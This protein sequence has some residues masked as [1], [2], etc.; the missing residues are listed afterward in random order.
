MAV[1]DEYINFNYGLIRVARSSL[2]NHALKL[3]IPRAIHTVIGRTD[4][5]KCVDCADVAKNNSW[6][7]DECKTVYCRNCVAKAAPV[8][9]PD[10]KEDEKTRAL[11]AAWR[12]T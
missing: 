12:G 1:A 6:V 3:M 2:H 10:G 4:P 5:V 7:C 9:S 8:E 11:I